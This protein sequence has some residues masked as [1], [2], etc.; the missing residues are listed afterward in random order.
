MIGELHASFEFATAL[1]A[2]HAWERCAKR[3]R[4]ISI[5]RWAMDFNDPQG[6][7]RAVTV[8]AE[9]DIRS[10]FE[11]A[12]A[13]LRA[14]T[15]IPTPDPELNAMRNKRIR[16]FLRGGEREVTRAPTGMIVHVSGIDLGPA[17]RPQG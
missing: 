6:S 2:K 7:G 1:Q 3:C 15:R 5:N 17:R 10:E 16:N 8:L 12:C 4:D 11:K 13:L 9:E 14:G